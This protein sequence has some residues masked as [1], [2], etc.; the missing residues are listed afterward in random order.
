MLL[1]TGLLGLG[2]APSL[3][4]YFAAWVV[5]GLGMGA[6]LYDAAFGTLGRLYGTEARSAITTLTLYG[7]FASTICWPL[8]ALLVEQLGWRGAA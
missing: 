5:L 2:F 4:F 6:G 7:G 3:P 1:A 8:S